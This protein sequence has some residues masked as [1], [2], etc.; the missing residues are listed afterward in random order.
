MTNSAMAGWPATPTGKVRDTGTCFLLMIVTLGFYSLYW[1]YRVH[2]EI[3]EHSGTGI[4]G[5]IALVLAIFVSPV[6]PFLSSNE[7]GNLYDR[8]GQT[9]PVSAITGLWPLLLGWF[10]LI[11]YIVWFVK[12]NDALNNHWRSLGAQG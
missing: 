6:M 10:F 7:V 5:P 9:A 1:Y 8:R 12:T 11:G 3:Q 4:G 2:R